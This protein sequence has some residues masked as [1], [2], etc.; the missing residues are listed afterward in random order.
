MET[1]GLTTTISKLDLGNFTVLSGAPTL[2]SMSYS[3]MKMNEEDLKK[4]DQIDGGRARVCV[5]ERPPP[6]EVEVLRKNNI[7][8]WRRDRVL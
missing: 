3:F 1:D 5:R 2:C 4:R 8:I 7:D 6:V